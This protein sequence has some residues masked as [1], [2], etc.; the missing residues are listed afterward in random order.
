MV[1]SSWVSMAYL[2]AGATF[3]NSTRSNRRH[4]NTLNQIKQNQNTKKYL[5]NLTEFVDANIKEK[6]PKQCLA[7]P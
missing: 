1:D 7:T 4:T 5:K 6:Y 3:R 2:H